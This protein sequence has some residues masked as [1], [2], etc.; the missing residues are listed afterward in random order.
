MSALS[1]LP[2]HLIHAFEGHTLPKHLGDSNLNQNYSFKIYAQ[3]S[4]SPVKLR[5]TLTSI[6][7]LLIGSFKQTVA[8]AVP[9]EDSHVEQN[10]KYIYITCKNW[11]FL[12]Q[13]FFSKI[14]VFAQQV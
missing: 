14:L 9:A 7:N 2:E 6:E 4:I 11:F 5:S 3:M 1:S 8:N 13:V 12:K 10:H